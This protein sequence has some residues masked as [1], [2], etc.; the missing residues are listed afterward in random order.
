MDIYI[1]STGFHLFQAFKYACKNK[2]NIL[3]VVGNRPLFIEFV[4]SIETNLLDLFQ[5]IH[6]F[7]SF[8]P[9]E[10]HYPWSYISKVRFLYKTSKE[11]NTFLELN[12]FLV[13]KK[14][15]FFNTNH[16]ELIFINRL[17]KLHSNIEIQHWEEGIG[18]YFIPHYKLGEKYSIKNFIR[19]IFF[20]SLNFDEISKFRFHFP[21]LIDE[22]LKA[23]I[24][25]EKIFPFE[26]VNSDMINSSR[27]SRQIYF[28]Q[29]NDNEFDIML[30]LFG[31]LDF[32]IKRHPATIEE[33]DYRNIS[34]LDFTPWE[35]FMEK[36]HVNNSFLVASNSTVIYT[37]LV[38]FNN[39]NNKSVL[40]NNLTATKRVP[41]VQQSDQLFFSRLAKKFPERIISL[42]NLDEL[43]EFIL[44]NLARL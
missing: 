36:K 16:F 43:K 40:V 14:I 29:E 3:M 19:K 5:D 23:V 37:H 18:S 13:Y 8:N 31:E 9:P 6:F 27:N 39:Y 20:L 38:F 10:I 25:K 15:V 4:K 26:V 41:A 35:F 2:E 12:S 1:C 21:E 11:I 28:F 32:F 17:K 33:K 30:N 34:E 44:T 7:H 22:E 24:V 42:N